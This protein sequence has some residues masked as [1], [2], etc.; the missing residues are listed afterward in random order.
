VQIDPD[1]AAR[2]ALLRPVVADLG[3]LV[4]CHTRRMEAQGIS[5]PMAQSTVIGALMHELARVI[6]A[7]RPALHRQHTKV[8]TNELG[9]L[10]AAAA[11]AMGPVDDEPDQRGAQ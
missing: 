5:F 3:D 2:T 1:I 10:V 11:V 8:V 4:I 9:R 7:G 6:A